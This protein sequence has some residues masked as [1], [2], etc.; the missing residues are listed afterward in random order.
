M[1]EFWFQHPGLLL[2][3][4]AFVVVVSFLWLKFVEAGNAKVAEIT[5]WLTD[6]PPAEILPPDKTRRLRP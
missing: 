2:A 5:H 1:L 4:V 3:V 6:E